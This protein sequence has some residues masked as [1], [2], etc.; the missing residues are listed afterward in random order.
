[1]TNYTELIKRIDM[2]IKMIEQEKN[3]FSANRD[4]AEKEWFENAGTEAGKTAMIKLN[5]FD[6][7]YSMSKHIL[8]LITFTGLEKAVNDY[9]EESNAE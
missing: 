9:K 4:Q 2:F 8:E 7:E 3:S 5:V 6:T 1:M